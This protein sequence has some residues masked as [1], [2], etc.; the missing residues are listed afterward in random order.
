[1]RDAIHDFNKRGLDALKAISSRPTEVHAAFDE[2]SALLSL[3]ELLHRSPGEFGRQSTLWTLKDAA[4]ISFKQGLTHKMV[5]GETI[6]ATLKRL[7]V[8]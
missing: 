3:R 2:Q 7:G 5:S 1:V 6:R 4:H 8:R